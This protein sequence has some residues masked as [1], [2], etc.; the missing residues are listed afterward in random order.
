[1][2]PVAK[3]L[4]YIESHY[5][6]DI[7]LDDIADC[8]GVSRFH[9]LRAFGA[10]TGQSIMR[11][12]RARRLAEAARRLIASADDILPV[13]LDAGY[14]SHEAFTRAFRDHFGVTPESVRRLRSVDHLS[15]QEQIPMSSVPTAKLSPPR[16]IDSKALLIA[17]LAE[18][19]D[20]ERSGAGIPGQW[21][22]FNAYIDSIPG[23]IG[24]LAYGVCYN[25]DDAGNM[26]YLCG[27]E[28]NEFSG[29]PPQF[30]HLR[31]PEHRYAVFLHKEHIS[32]IR[33]TWNAIWNDW[34]PQSDHRVADAPFF[35][36]YGES[37]DP[38]SGNGG[39]ELWV[40]VEK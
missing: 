35:E 31:I 24:K 28:V 4:W 14:G 7:S 5:G 27:V 30:S 20:C 1:M 3:A 23:R 16:F 18:H 29:L 34:L 25:T 37:F 33:G 15:L 2:N 17:G 12:V 11:Y 22:K 39:V 10:A 26:D 32:A 9:L 19:Y 6:Q 38:R 21:Q 36:L 8:A 40:P 13:A